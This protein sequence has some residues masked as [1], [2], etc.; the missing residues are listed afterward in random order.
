MKH[1]HHW[2]GAGTI[3]KANGESAAEYNWCDGCGCLKYT[4]FGDVKTVSCIWRPS[5]LPIDKSHGHE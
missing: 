1:R 5:H 2:I 3:L 4:V